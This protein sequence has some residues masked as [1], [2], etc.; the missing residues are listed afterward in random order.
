MHETLDVRRLYRNSH[1]I[2]LFHSHNDISV[3]LLILSFRRLDNHSELVSLTLRALYVQVCKDEVET[4]LFIDVQVSWIH[5]ELNA[6]FNRLVDE[7]DPF[8]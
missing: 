5:L 4:K 7:F 3:V 6:R 2:S 8:R 1:L